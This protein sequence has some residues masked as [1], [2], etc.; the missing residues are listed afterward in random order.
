MTPSHRYEPN[1]STDQTWKRQLWESQ[2]QKFTL[3]H[4]LA[5]MAKP[6][7]NHGSHIFIYEIPP[8]HHI[9]A[10]FPARSCLQQIKYI[11]PNMNV[12]SCSTDGIPI[13]LRPWHVQEITHATVQWH[14]QNVAGKEHVYSVSFYWIRLVQEK[15]RLVRKTNRLFSYLRQSWQSQ[16]CSSGPQRRTGRASRS[17]CPQPPLS[18]FSTCTQSPPWG[19][20]LNRREH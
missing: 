2:R 11:M 19:S 7:N 18:S 9:R 6:V 12:V 15:K 10:M 13:Q 17:E 5:C 8:H 14:K 16:R 1:Q 20:H 3:L 4:L